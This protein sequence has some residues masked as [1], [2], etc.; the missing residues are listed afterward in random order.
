MNIAVRIMKILIVVIV[1]TLISGGI[2]WAT[3]TGFADAAAFKLASEDPSV[4]IAD[5]GDRIEIT[6]NTDETFDQAYIFYPGG[7]IMPDA[8]IYRLSRLARAAQIRVVIVKFWF[9]LA[10]TDV[11]AADRV[12]AAHPEVTD[13]VIG[14]HSLGGAM[15][16]RFAAARGQELRGLILQASY[17]DQDISQTA[18][19]VLS[20]IGTQDGIV[21]RTVWQQ[22][23]RHLPAEYMLKEIQGLNHSQFGNY[24]QQR[25][26]SESS[27]P[28]AQANQEIL[29]AMSYLIPLDLDK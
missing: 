19:P 9:N 29:A 27:I 10:V 28:E 21:D 7:L 24:G 26:D 13:W 15:A 17:C 16:C 25:G 18:L 6:P 2:W 22:N 12:I 8:Y 11:N 5:V 4:K 3:G 1:L 20:I 14:G 23:I